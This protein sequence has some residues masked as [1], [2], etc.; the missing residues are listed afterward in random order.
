MIDCVKFFSSNLEDLAKRRFMI[1]GKIDAFYVTPINIGDSFEDLRK[2]KKLKKV[3]SNFCLGKGDKNW[4]IK[5]NFNLFE[6]K[7]G[8]ERAIKV[9]IENNGKES[10]E[11][12]LYINNKI[13]EGIDRNHYV[14]FLDDITGLKEENNEALVKLYTGIKH[15][16]NEEKYRYWRD[17][18]FVY[19]HEATNKLYNELRALYELWK[20]YSQEV[21]EHYVIERILIESLNR[22]D[23]S[24]I[25][26]EFYKQIE[27]DWE[28]L[29][30]VLLKNKRKVY[31]KAIFIGHGHLDISW[32]WTYEV[33]KEKAGRT[34][35]NALR[36]MDRYEDFKYIQSQPILYKFVKERY[37]EIYK[38]I[39]E[40]VAKGMWEVEGGMWCEADC[41]IP[42]SESL[43]RQLLYGKRF[44]KEEFNVDSKVAWLPDTFGFSGSLP[45]ILKKSGIEYFVTTKLSWSQYNEFP[46]NTFLWKGIDGSEILSYIINTP[47]IVWGRGLINDWITVYIGEGT[48]EEVVGAIKEYKERRINSDVLM[49]IGEGDGG[50]GPDWRMCERTNTKVMKGEFGLI[51]VEYKKVYDYLKEIE[52]KTQ[53]KL[54]KWDDELYLEYHRGTYTT[55]GFVKRLNKL[56]ETYLLQT[57]FIVELLRRNFN[58]IIN[59]N[60]IYEKLKENWEQVLTSQFH[61]IIT[62][63]S[64]PE[65]Y[66]I[67]I[68]DLNK[69]LKS[70]SDLM[71][72]LIN[73]IV[74][75]NNK[76]NLVVINT[77][78]FERSGIIRMGDGYKKLKT[79]ILPF[80]VKVLSKDDFEEE[81]NNINVNTHMLE[82]DLLKIEFD[83]KYYFIKNIFYKKEYREI[84]QKGER[85]NNF[86]LYEDRP[87]FKFHSAWDIDIN[88]K[89]KLIEESGRVINVTSYNNGIRG[90]I[91]IERKIGL[92]SYIK[93]NVYIVEGKRVIYFD[94]EIEWGERERLLKVHFPVDIR[95][96]KALYEIQYGYIERPTHYNTSWDYA[97]FEVPCQRWAVLSDSEIGV[98]L[99]N[100]GKYGYSIYEN[101]I[102]LSLLRSPVYPDPSADRGKH[103][104]Q[105]ALM[106]FEK[107]NLWEVWREAY[108]IN[109]P[110]LVNKGNIK[111]NQ[112]DDKSMI[113]IDGKGVIVENIKKT[114]KGEGSV[115]RMYEA[116]G[117]KRRVRVKI[118]VDFNQIY[119]INLIEDEKQEINMIKDNTLDIEFNP[120]EIKSFLIV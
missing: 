64:I 17:V 88:Y 51:K 81:G 22:I 9:E 44:F 119:E 79:K 107:N 12:L 24:I 65:V 92:K 100:N 16:L 101:D 42:G 11:G 3:K 23:F 33:T 27:K 59:E 1:E 38:R 114:E 73:K 70:L 108:E 82:N 43:I 58:K 41:N 74:I 117:G 61:D 120:F 36:L 8:F 56:C 47:G 111:Y 77:T 66:K 109:Y 18:L 45:Q 68:K 31:N 19:M 91:I 14:I 52:K 20:Y 93:Q 102:S 90:G 103:K 39:K 5:F 97:K 116:L 57:E 99:L 55:Y 86:K 6:K 76:N 34:F 80:S 112:L 113:E 40:Y 98:A 30:D 71:E 83:N 85:G 13:I 60:D 63:T 110:L 35:S 32:L 7:K 26:E 49:A 2:K 104:F 10:L 50:G 48:M 29:K 15:P 53:G 37:P 72:I 25:G 118:N 67:V 95:S 87:S 28:I 89:D 54:H 46:Y 94:T 62:G 105:Y 21:E 115:I 78:S 69:V 4:L 106:T 96:R 75:K 84:L